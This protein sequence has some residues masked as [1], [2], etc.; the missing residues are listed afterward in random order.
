MAL[1]SLAPVSALEVRLGVDV[2]SL[3]GADLAR[4]E[5]DLADASALVRNEAG[6]D[7]VAVDGVTITAPD[8]VV[9]VVVRAALRSYRNPD[10]YQGENL[11]GSYSYQY[12][13]G[14]TGVYL[15]ADEIRVVQLA[16]RGAGTGGLTT[17]RVLPAYDRTRRPVPREEW[18]HP[19][20]WRWSL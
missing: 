14:E 8:P 10:G 18:D 5:A 4:A 16:A 13:Q 17:V 7:W 11:G 3:A 19:D 2:G 12:A 20:P 1:P 15:T 9:A 6:C